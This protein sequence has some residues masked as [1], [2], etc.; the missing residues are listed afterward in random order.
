MRV[1]YLVTY[2]PRVSHTF[3][4]R[5]IAALEQQGLTVDRFAI[6]GAPDAIVDPED[7]RE[8]ERTRVLLS[9]PK[10][11]LLFAVLAA[12]LLRPLRFL[13]ALRLT[14]A[15]VRASDRGAIRNFAYLVEACILLGWIKRTDCSHVH[16]HFGTNSAAAAMLCHELGGPPYSFTV[17]G[18]DEFDAVEGL[19]LRDKIERA[20][21]VVAIS[22]FGRSQ[23]WRHCG[24][25]HWAKVQIVRCGLD[26]AFLDAEPQPIPER[27]RL[28]SVGRITAQ[29]G[30]PLLL[31]A[32]KR[33][34]AE[35]VAFELVLV[36]D[37]E[38][39][40]ELEAQIAQSGLRER[41][42]LIG[43]ADGERVRAELR[44]ARAFV[45]PSFAEGLPV[46]IMEALALGRPVISTYVA[47]IPE[48]VGSDCGWLVPAGSV[49]PLVDAMRAAL[50]ASPAQ[51][52]AMGE[53]GRER[54]RKQHDV[55]VESQKLRALL[56]RGPAG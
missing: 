31:E 18:P 30:Y 46:V 53:V 23:L 26:G 52:G 43:L 54:V 12:A 41:V 25:A 16:A 19:S 51:L 22:S 21:F 48:L 37:G 10:L 47:G 49:D 32:A 33:L 1:A 20:R 36:G 5:E 9:A 11:E 40:A 44:A 34:A 55:R 8:A 2:Y 45:L 42:L 39:R 17:H 35:G 4:R 56:E 13:R 27:P 7:Q 14:F 15:L 3:I 50:T 6:R 28:V 29:K 38:M 24:Y